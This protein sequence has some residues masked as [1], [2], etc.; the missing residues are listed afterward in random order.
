MHL[1]NYSYS[2][3]RRKKKEERKKEEHQ[4]SFSRLLGSRLISYS[5]HKSGKTLWPNIVLPRQPYRWCRCSN[6]RS[7]QT[8]SGICYTNT[9]NTNTDTVSIS[10]SSNIN[11]ED[12]MFTVEYIPP[13]VMKI[14]FTAPLVVRQKIHLHFYCQHLADVLIQSDLQVKGLA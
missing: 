2:K 14:N 13:L 5:L 12:K 1:Q 10:F 6:P 11:C 7:R 4:V 9:S 8:G 3:K